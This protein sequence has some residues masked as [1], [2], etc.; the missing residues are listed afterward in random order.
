MLRVT[1]SAAAE[2]LL[3]APIFPDCAAIV[4]VEGADELKVVYGWLFFIEVALTGEIT[5]RVAPSLIY[6]VK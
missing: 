1:V 4:A 5:S 3:F 2:F 6:I